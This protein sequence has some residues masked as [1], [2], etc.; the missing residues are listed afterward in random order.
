MPNNLKL[1]LFG[2][3]G[4][5][6]NNHV[7]LRIGICKNSTSNNFK[8]F[9]EDFIR[10]KMASFFV[11]FIYKDSYVDS[12]DYENPV[13]YYVTS[14]TLKSSSYNFRQD[15]YLYK[16]ISFTTD[17]GM[18]MPDFQNLDGLQLDYISS[19]NTADPKTEVFTN[20][21]IGL[22][23]IKGNY[24]R[25]YI[26]VQDISAQVGGLIK[27]FM[28][29]FE[30]LLSFY[31]YAPFLEDL[32]SKIISTEVKELEKKIE[33]SSPHN[34]NFQNTQ[35][36]LKKN[37][38]L[39]KIPI[40]EICGK[41]KTNVRFRQKSYSFCDVIFRCFQVNQKSKKYNYLFYIQRHYESTFDLKEI[42]LSNR[43]SH[44][45]YKEKNATNLISSPRMD[46]L[47]SNN[48]NII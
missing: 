8:C 10:E 18:I 4:A 45:M 20:V 19:S 17:S 37:I 26:K 44:I 13:K 15:A 6:I 11:S 32:Y 41:Q 40:K 30:V 35:E 5:P 1:Q 2:K 16:N 23:N 47:I 27:F 46:N 24:S 22:N 7:H 34:R 12:K 39:N 48:E 43:K 36:V 33:F 31:S 9:P 28:V 42:I 14:Y 25:S 29:V 38:Q 3:Y 21:I